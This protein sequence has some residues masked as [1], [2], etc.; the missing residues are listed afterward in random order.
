MLQMGF[1]PGARHKAADLQFVRENNM[2][3]TIFFENFGALSPHQ[4]MKV[5]LHL[6]SM[7]TFRKLDMLCSEC[8]A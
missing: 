1:E 4:L 2:K 5:T 8:K 7:K 6:T 3:V